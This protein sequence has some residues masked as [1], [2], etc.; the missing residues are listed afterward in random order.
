MDTV[1]YEDLGRAALYGDPAAV[2]VIRDLAGEFSFALSNLICLVHPRLIVLGGNSVSL[3][4]V[5]LEE[6]RRSLSETGFARMTENVKL[7]YSQL[8]SY[9]CYNGAMK[10]FFDIHYQFTGSMKGS[11]FIG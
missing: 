5:F 3:G 4:S 10:Y 7:R 8:D 1:R 11:F 2:Q 9:A 6:I